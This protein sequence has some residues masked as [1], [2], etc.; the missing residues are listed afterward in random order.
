M[1]TTCSEKIKNIIRTVDFFGTFISFRVDQEIIHK[2]LIGGACTIIYI[3]IAL[4]YILYMAIPFLKRKEINFTF[5]NKIVSKNPFVNLTS[6]N[7]IFA[8]GPLYSSDAASAIED[9]LK[10][11]TY[12][13]NIIEWIGIDDFFSKEITFEFCNQSN[14]PSSLNEQFEVNELNELYCPIIENNLN[15]S[16]DGLYTDDYYKFITID[17]ILSDYGK[18]KFEEVKEFIQENPLLMSVFF[19]DTAIDYENRKF[20]LPSYI[21]YITKDIDFDYL[22]KSEIFLSSL[23][24]SND[25]SFFI[26]KQSLTKNIMFD[27]SED[28]FR[29]IED[30]I[31][32]NI[33][34]IFQIEIKVSPKITTLKRKYQKLPEF[35]ASLSGLL[36][37]FLVVMLVC[38]HLMEK[39]AINQKL[40]HKM[41]KFKGNTNININYLI[42]KFK[43]P[44][45]NHTNE[46]SNTIFENSVKNNFE[47]NINNSVKTEKK[48]MNKLFSKI[49][50]E[51]I[52]N[53]DNKIEESD[54]SLQNR[55][56]EILS[57]NSIY[58]SQK[59][60]KRKHKST[61][62]ELKE[63]IRGQNIFVGK[64]PNEKPFKKEEQN[65]LK[66][67]IFQIICNVFCFWCSPRIKRKRILLLQ[68]ENKINYYMDI[69]TYIKTIQE[70]ELLKDMLLDKKSLKLFEFLSKSAM[71]IVN[72]RLVFCHRFGKEIVPFKR[73]NEYEIDKLYLIYQKMIHDKANL[74]KEKQKLI[75]FLKNEINFLE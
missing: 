25:D 1:K 63:L 26:N 53:I 40:I 51:S 17:M 15:Y 23:E 72:D 4:I 14:F 36:S 55:K 70:F 13:I 52:P 21:N 64:I 34:D 57:S 20:P 44:T 58:S 69:I 31:E 7:F 29:V 75:N 46:K 10:F 73:M 8:F 38:S 30:R 42:D 67:N 39:K 3:I 27:R 56:V 2:S 5:S 74:P 9:T 37:F 24:F 54:K 16:V 19:I 66:L 32:Q 41:L 12:K 18:S 33:Y 60:M 43:N 49:N 22:K 61:S 6:S 71:K 47:K 62:K 48:K 45:F 50:L 11:F 59:T 68:A 65:F 28:S 35:V